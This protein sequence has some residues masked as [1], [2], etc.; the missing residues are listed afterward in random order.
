MNDPLDRIPRPP[1]PEQLDP[2]VALVK[3]YV[4]R[5]AQAMRCFL[6][7]M[8]EAHDRYQARI[9]QVANWLDEQVKKIEGEGETDS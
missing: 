9:A 8:R 4:D 2:M 3:G 6:E 7:E 5:R 1:A